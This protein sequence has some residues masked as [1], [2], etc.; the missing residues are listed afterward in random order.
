LPVVSC[1]LGAPDDSHLS[2]KMPIAE[3]KLLLYRADHE[4]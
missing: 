3:G 1:Q 2:L 4:K